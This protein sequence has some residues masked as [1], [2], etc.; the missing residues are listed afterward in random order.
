MAKDDYDVMVYRVLVY[1][2]ACLKRKIAFDDATFQETVRKHTDSEAYW[3]DVLNMMQGEGLLSG[4][5]FTRAWGHDLILAS[6]P[7]DAQITAAGIHY[8]KE[9]G[10]MNKAGEFLKEC[11]DMI[12]TLAQLVGLIT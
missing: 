11:K 6:S 9:N 4:L 12:F 3:N 10:A 5:T 8:L 1:Y 7:R 2:Y